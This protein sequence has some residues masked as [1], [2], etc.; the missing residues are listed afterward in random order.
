M[1]AEKNV[2]RAIFMIWNGRYGACMWVVRRK[3]LMIEERKSKVGR[4]VI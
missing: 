3:G 1:K 2:E 4:V